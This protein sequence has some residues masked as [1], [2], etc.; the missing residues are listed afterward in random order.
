MEIT[1]PEKLRDAVSK[2]VITIDYHLTRDGIDSWVRFVQP[3]PRLG[4]ATS[5]SFRLEDVDDYL[6]KINGH[7]RQPS[8]ELQ[9]REVESRRGSPPAS[10]TVHEVPVKEIARQLSL[11]HLLNTYQINGLA[12]S[13]AMDSLH[14]L[15]L[16]LP[17]DM[18]G[19]RIRLVLPTEERAVARIASDSR[20]HVESV[21]SLQDWWVRSTA[22]QKWILLTK[23]SKSGE[24]QRAS[25]KGE[26]HV[27]R[28]NSFRCPF[29]DTDLKAD[30]SEES[31][32]GYS[33]TWD[34]GLSLMRANRFK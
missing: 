4:V 29:R 34:G 6:D 30:Q 9:E 17:I 20:L 33:Q 13:K 21:A 23:R 12:Q 11:R 28:L 5:T 10:P 7:S 3:H 15:D 19:A 25:F 16:N 14:L 32:S 8:R 27:S 31:D 24:T 22:I 26:H 18:L 2:G 1:V